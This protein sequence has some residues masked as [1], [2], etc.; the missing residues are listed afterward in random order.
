[1]AARWPIQVGLT[2]AAA[3]LMLGLV[4]AAPARSGE[5]PTRSELSAIVETLRA[6]PDLKATQ[7]TK[8]LRL[9]RSEPEAPQ[10]PQAPPSWWLQWVR[11]IREALGWLA[12]TTRWLIWLLGALALAL[13]VVSVRRWARERADA[14]ADSSPPPPSHVGALDVR[15]GSLPDRIG[16]HARALWLRGEHRAALSLL[17]R[18]ALSRLI[19]VYAVPIRAAHTESECVRLA[20][21]RLQAE[22]SAFFARLVSI[23]QLAVYGGRDPEAAGV[24]SLC[25]QFDLLMGTAASKG[26]H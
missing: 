16:A 26:A 7:R 15:P 20:Q 5:L 23:W 10:A 12:E 11:W 19:H 14:E 21:G 25:D 17:Y 4:G 6:D 24:L 1:L 22:V 18:G 8:V 9:K 3:V 13:I 2:A